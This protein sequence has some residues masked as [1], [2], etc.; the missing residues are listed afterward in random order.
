[1][2][3]D[4][5]P[6]QV[7]DLVHCKRRSARYEPRPTLALRRACCGLL[8]A[9]SRVAGKGRLASQQGTVAAAL[10]AS[11]V[12]APPRCTRESL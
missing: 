12:C 2:A 6:H 3:T 8:S 10:A 1:M 7:R 4:C 5:V 9:A 11:L